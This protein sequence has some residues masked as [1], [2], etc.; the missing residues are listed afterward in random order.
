MPPPTTR[1]LPGSAD[2]ARVAREVRGLVAR[3]HFSDEVRSRVLLHLG[4]KG[5]ILHEGHAAP[6]SYLTLATF[7][8]AIHSGDP[9]RAVPAAASME[10]L[11]ACGDLLDDVEDDEGPSIFDSRSA[12]PVMEDVCILLLLSHQALGELTARGFDD[13]TVVQAYKILDESSI[14]AIRGQQVDAELESRTSVSLTQC[15][16][17]TAAK[18]ASLTKCAAEMGATLAGADGSIAALYG[19]F[20]WHL[21]MA[22][23]I[24]NDIEGV[25]PGRPAKSDI[26]LRKK[27]LPVVATLNMPQET[28]N[29]VALV[30][31]FFSSE[32]SNERCDADVEE[33]VRWAL[34][35]CGGI[36]RAWL[37][38]NLQRLAAAR[39][40]TELSAFVPSAVALDR[41]IA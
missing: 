1:N 23:Q 13:R 32:R 5:R 33:E 3:A 8:S 30:R 16:E 12:A 9:A 22:A 11:M 31:R 10:F 18:S 17:T 34:W 20:G 26:R 24:A 38:A 6:T 35:R 36:R 25:W 15:L 39:T 28:D 37:A 4:A 27:T 29:D 14:S 7:A 40:L 41:L 2:V 19:Q 21:G